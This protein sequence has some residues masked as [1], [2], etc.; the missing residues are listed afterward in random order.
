MID[1][2]KN[3]GSSAQKN[4]NQV[5]NKTEPKEVFITDVSE[6]GVGDLK[7]L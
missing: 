3:G 6:V 1:Q 2:R 5:P 4:L 7:Y